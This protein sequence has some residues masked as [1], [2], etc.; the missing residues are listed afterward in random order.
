MTTLSREVETVKQYL[1]IQDY[2]YK[3]HFRVIWDIDDRLM[4]VQVPRSILQP[5]IEN[6][7]YHGI[8]VSSGMGIIHV[9]GKFEDGVV[10]LDITDNGVGISPK[11]LQQIREHSL[12]DKSDG[13]MRSVGLDNVDERIKHTCGKEY[14]LEISS[15]VGKYTKTVIRLPIKAQ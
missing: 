3:G 5:I 10:L 2:R 15:N 6:S 7:L 13:R 8:L 9:S 14:G 1:T 11:T 4:D 12:R